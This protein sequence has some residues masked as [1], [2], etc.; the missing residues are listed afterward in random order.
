LES[1]IHQIAGEPLEMYL[2]H[3]RDQWLAELAWMAPMIAQ[4]FQ[5]VNIDYVFRMRYQG[6]TLRLW[7][8]HRD[9]ALGGMTPLAEAPLPKDLWFSP[10]A[11]MVSWSPISDDLAENLCKSPSS[12]A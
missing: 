9:Q 11:Q 6:N 5:D 2:V 3:L 8:G 12:P 4:F 10:E 1:Q 7:F